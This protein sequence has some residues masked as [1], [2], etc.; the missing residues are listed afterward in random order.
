MYQHVMFHLHFTIWVQHGYNKN[1]PLCSATLILNLLRRPHNI[2]TV[3]QFVLMQMLCTDI[4]VDDVVLCEYTYSKASEQRVWTA[5]HFVGGR[6]RN[7]KDSNILDLRWE[8]SVAF[9]EGCLVCGMYKTSWIWWFFS[10][11][12]LKELEEEWVKVSAAAPKQTRFLRSQQELKAKFEQQQAVGGDGDGGKLL[13]LFSG[14]QRLSLI[15]Y[16][17]TNTSVTKVSLFKLLQNKW[18]AQ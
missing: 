3:L 15:R 12:Q 2:L 11:W 1:L 18:N 13:T 10:L 9:C 16:F 7:L 14:V 17:L 8:H 6:K 4:F 5:S